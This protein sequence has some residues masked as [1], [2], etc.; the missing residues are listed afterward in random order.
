M[1][2]RVYYYV[3]SVGHGA[4]ADVIVQKKRTAAVMRRSFLVLFFDLFAQEHGGGFG[5]HGL[6][7]G[8]KLGIVGSHECHCA[9]YIAVCEDRGDGEGVGGDTLD[10]SKRL[11]CGIGIVKVFAVFQ[12]L[13]QG[14]GEAALGLLFFRHA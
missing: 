9:C 13:L 11:G 5:K 6:F 12:K 4:M 14:R 3:G 7:I 1:G 10:G 2:R 8:T